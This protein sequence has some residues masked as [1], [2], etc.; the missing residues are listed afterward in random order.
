MT[1]PSTQFVEQRVLPLVLAFAAGVLVMDVA[2][3]RRE[4]D[5]VAIA[6]HAVAV[7]ERYHDACGPVWPPEDVP[8]A[9]V[10][11]IVAEVRP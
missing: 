1:R 5:L 6:E 11:R 8:A 4:S 3:D 9:D 10:A 7:A 2:Q